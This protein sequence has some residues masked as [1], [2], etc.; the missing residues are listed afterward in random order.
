MW[1]KQHKT[2]ANP[3]QNKLLGKK[4][5][6]KLG[7][8]CAG[9]EVGQMPGHAD[10]IGF[11]LTFVRLKKFLRLKKKSKKEKIKKHGF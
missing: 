1:G 5:S 7:C 3:K 10:A 9:A 11:A 4:C 2:T 8:N 6:G